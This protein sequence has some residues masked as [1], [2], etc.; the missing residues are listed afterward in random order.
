[1]TTPA[2]FFQLTAKPLFTMT[3]GEVV[4]ALGGD[5]TLFKILCDEFGLRPVHRRITKKTYRVDSVQDAL[6]EKELTEELEN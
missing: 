2:T 5:E 6:R 4:A 1:M 3:R